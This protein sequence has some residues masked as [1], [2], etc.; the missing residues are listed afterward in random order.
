MATVR[1]ESASH[2]YTT[3]GEPCHEVPRADGN[4]MRA[5]TLADARKLGLLPSVTNVLSVLNKPYLNAWKATQYIEAFMDVVSSTPPEDGTDRVAAAVELAEQRMAMPRDL[6]TLYHAAIADTIQC[7]EGNRNAIR[8]WPPEVD[9][10]TLTAVVEWYAAHCSDG[11]SEKPFASTAGYGGCVD[12]YG[13]YREDPLDPADEPEFAV[14]DFKTQATTPGKA[15]RSY[16]EWAVQLAAYANGIGVS[17]ALLMNL[18]ISTTEP[19]RIEVVDWPEGVEY[20]Y[21]NFLQVFAVWRS[22]LG[23]NFDPRGE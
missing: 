7:I 8:V 12:W 18:V 2:W 21:H 23:R 17:D 6:G 10:V 13:F 20:W 1:V 4:G 16:N 15:I 5:T 3:L 9:M 19:G 22:A 14:V 11:T